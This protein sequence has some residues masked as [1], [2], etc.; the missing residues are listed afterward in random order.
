MNV[1]MVIIIFV[2]VA[3]GSN[4]LLINAKPATPSIIDLLPRWPIY[5]IYLELIGL[6]TC[7]ILYLPFIVQNHRSLRKRV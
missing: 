5:I 4:Y 6:V 3:L 7:F 1:Y 2:N